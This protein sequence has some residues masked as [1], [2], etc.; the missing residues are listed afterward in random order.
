MGFSKKDTISVSGANF[1]RVTTKMGAIAFTIR[2]H[3]SGK[4]KTKFIVR[5]F[6]F[7]HAKTR[8]FWSDIYEVTK[9]A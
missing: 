7:F 2:R 1:S 8:S 3:M 5:A 4:N 6:F 9:N